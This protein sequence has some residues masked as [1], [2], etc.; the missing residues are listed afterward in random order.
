MASNGDYNDNAFGFIDVSKYF[1]GFTVTSESYR[2]SNRLL[3]YENKDPRIPS[4]VFH[5][6]KIKIRPFRSKPLSNIR[7]IK[8][9]I[10]HSFR[11][12]RSKK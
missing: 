7:C 9:F 3:T 12:G 11:I 5:D 2:C 8:Q 1:S 4:K 10:G 6:R